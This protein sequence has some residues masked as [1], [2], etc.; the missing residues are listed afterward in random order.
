MYFFMSKLGGCWYGWFLEPWT[1][2]LALILCFGSSRPVRGGASSACSLDISRYG[3]STIS[4]SWDTT[5]SALNSL[6]SPRG[7]F[8]AMLKPI[9]VRRIAAECCCFYS[10]IRLPL[11]DFPAPDWFSGR[12]CAFEM[13]SSL[14]FTESSACYIMFSK[15]PFRPNAI[16]SVLFIRLMFLLLYGS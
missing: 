12:L 2:C 5:G 7:M 6:T 11:M 16:I 8:V 4:G 10:T 3:W 14:Y 15:V 9:S 1:R 13:R